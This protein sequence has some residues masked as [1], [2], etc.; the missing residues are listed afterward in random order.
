MS[1]TYFIFA[2]H[3]VYALI[4]DVINTDIARMLDFTIDKKNVNRRLGIGD[5][6]QS[7]FSYTFLYR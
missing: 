4:D 3:N 5:A 2:S 7:Q 1:R 6:K